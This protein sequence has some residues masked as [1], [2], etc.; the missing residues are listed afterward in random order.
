MLKKILSTLLVAAVGV[1]PL[2][3]ADKINGAGASF[4]APLYTV[5]HLTIEKTQKIV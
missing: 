2:L 1:T 5:G 3:A 4:P